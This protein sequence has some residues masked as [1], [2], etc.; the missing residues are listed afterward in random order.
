MEYD[1]NTLKLEYERD[2]AKGLDS[3]K[4]PYNYFPEDD[5]S[6]T[7][8]VTWRSPGQLLYTN[9]LNFVYQETPYD[10]TDIPP[11]AEASYT[12][13]LETDDESEN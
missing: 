11:L 1:W 4:L 9:W 8:L 6:K 13:T 2:L 3:V 10:L 7:P 5:P 12:R